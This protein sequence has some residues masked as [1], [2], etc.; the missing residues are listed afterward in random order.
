MCYPVR[1]ARGNPSVRRGLS[2]QCSL[3]TFSLFCLFCWA[4]KAASSLRKKMLRLSSPDRHQEKERL[5]SKVT[6]H[7]ASQWLNA[8]KT[9]LGSA[10]PWP[11]R[12]GWCFWSRSRIGNEYNGSCEVFRG[13][14]VFL[15]GNQNKTWRAALSAVDSILILTCPTFKTRCSNLN[16]S[17]PR[18]FCVNCAFSFCHVIRVQG[19]SGFYFLIA[20]DWWDGTSEEGWL[21]AWGMCPEAER[22]LRMGASFMVPWEHSWR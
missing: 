16:Q 1:S 3:Q 21:G 19:S 9:G 8:A 17:C 4:K 13:R 11:S 10:S 20:P 22:P 12:V 6:S 5:P 15:L 14:R 7:S 2:L 18:D